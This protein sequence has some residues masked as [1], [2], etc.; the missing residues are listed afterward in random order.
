MIAKNALNVPCLPIDEYLQVFH[1]DY[2]NSRE[3]KG[4]Q[5]FFLDGRRAAA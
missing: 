4:T 2:T 1:E 3:E 5:L